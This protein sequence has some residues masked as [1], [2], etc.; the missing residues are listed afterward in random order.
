MSDESERAPFSR[1]S[2]PAAEAWKCPFV[3]V[4]GP[5][6]R[7]AVEVVGFEW[8]SRAWLEMPLIARTPNAVSAPAEIG[9]V[10][11]RRSSYH[12]GLAVLPLA[13]GMLLAG[14]TLASGTGTA[15]APK[16]LPPT[17][18]LCIHPGMIGGEPTWVV[19][20]ALGD[21]CPAGSLTDKVNTNRE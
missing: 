9:D 8:R 17:Y 11:M 21:R 2:A 4:Y 14:T 16:S 12:K 18:R 19:V 10:D 6:D 13:F 5:A 1:G 20:G 3:A 15:P 7:D